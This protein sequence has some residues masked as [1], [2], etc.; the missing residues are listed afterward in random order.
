[1]CV[2]T[3]YVKK[4]GNGNYLFHSIAREGVLRSKIRKKKEM[5]ISEKREW[6][7]IQQFRRKVQFHQWWEKKDNG[8]YYTN[9]EWDNMFEE[10]K[11]KHQNVSDEIVD[12]WFNTWL[13]QRN[14]FMT[15]TKATLAGTDFNTLPD[16]LNF[17]RIVKMREM[18]MEKKW[19][20]EREKIKTR[21]SAEIT[22]SKAKQAKENERTKEVFERAQQQQNTGSERAQSPTLSLPV[23]EQDVAATTSS[24]MPSNANDTTPTRSSSAMSRTHMNV[25]P[26]VRVKQEHRS[27]RRQYTTAEIPSHCSLSMLNAIFGLPFTEYK[28]IL[29]NCVYEKSP[30]LK[31]VMKLKRLKRL[32]IDLKYDTEVFEKRKKKDP[33]IIEWVVQNCAFLEWYGIRD[34]MIVEWYELLIRCCMNGFNYAVENEY[35]LGMILFSALWLAWSIMR[36]N[37]ENSL[38]AANGM[39]EMPNRKKWMEARL[40]EYITGIY[41][42]CYWME[43]IVQWIQRT[44]NVENRTT[45]IAKFERLDND[46][47]KADLNAVT[48]LS[49]F[50][51]LSVR[52]LFETLFVLLTSKF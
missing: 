5:K 8:E 46:N 27:P 28:T 4:T 21:I 49:F 25:Q 32:K 44:F 33:K 34:D 43:T 52:L 45:F 30:V 40:S 23:L 35:T 15:S 36:F 12:Q 1:M 47:L 20:A 22:K 3:D 14:V 7:Q 50:E 16:A 6:Y 19:L 26:T 2:E 18:K 37:V 48:K 42:K 29:E 10:Y 11:Q 39:T 41:N 38:A 51:T 17:V 31:D 13:V 24:S 9:D